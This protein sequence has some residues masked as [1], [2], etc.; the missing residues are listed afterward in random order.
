[1]Q[2]IAAK[3]KEKLEKIMDHKNIVVVYHYDLDGCVSAAILWRVFKKHNI[4]AEFFPAT[5][6]YDSI[7]I[8]KIKSHGFDKIVFV[9]YFPRKDYANE[10][11]DYNVSVIDHHQHEDYLE[12]FDYL[13][14]ADYGNDVAISYTLSKVAEGFGIKNLSWLAFI[15]AYWDKVLEKTE[16]YKKG[17]YK[18]KIDNLL[19]FNLVAS[20]TQTKGSI[21]VFE[22]LKS[23]SS[24]EDA[25]EKI[26]ELDDYR[27]AN[28]I[29]KEERKKINSTRKQYPKLM[30]EIFFLKTK[31]KHM[32][33]HVDYITFTEKGTFVFI[34]DEKIRYKFS[35]RTSL[36]INLLK[37]IKN[38]SNRIPYF[39]GGGHIKACGGLL[40]DTDLN[41]FLEKFIEEYKKQL[42][43]GKIKS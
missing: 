28:E 8:N 41:S 30:L 14:T 42:N 33:I 20:L 37:V 31:F 19:P 3:V 7:T 32:R 21:K 2:K 36:D 29:F 35:F 13:T 40:D 15:G 27:K 1:M 22:I 12:I 23:A 6:G 24:L 25:L 43:Q 11:K 10:L 4:N 34:L 39:G 18:E 26:K 9:D 17:I 5:R 16:F 38:L